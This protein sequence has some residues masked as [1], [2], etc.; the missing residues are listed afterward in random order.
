LIP[1]R[2]FVWLR[3]LMEPKLSLCS[4]V[5][6]SR[7]L[8]TPRCPP[9]RTINRTTVA[10]SNQTLS[11]MAASHSDMPSLACIARQT[12]SAAAA[13]AAVRI[14]HFWGDEADLPRRAGRAERSRRLSE[15]FALPGPSRPRRRPDVRS[16]GIKNIPERLFPTTLEMASELWQ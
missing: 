13:G 15:S 6:R 3:G 4:D 10:R 5:R 14:P 16:P 2:L 11:A 7:S 1:I 8:T 9:A 12:R